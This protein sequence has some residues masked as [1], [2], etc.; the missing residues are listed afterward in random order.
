M[1]IPWDNNMALLRAIPMNPQIR[2]MRRIVPNFGTALPLELDIDA[3]A[4][5]LIGFL[6]ADPVYHAAYVNEVASISSRCLHAR[7]YDPGLQRQL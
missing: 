5:P 4:W 1:W 7:V 2:A 3:D 6:L